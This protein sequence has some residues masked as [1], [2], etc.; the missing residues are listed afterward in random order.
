MISPDSAR[1]PGKRVAILGADGFEESEL[2]QPRAALK[3]AG[4]AS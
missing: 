4:A 1:L 2:L 3:E